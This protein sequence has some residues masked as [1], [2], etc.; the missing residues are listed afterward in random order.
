MTTTES[1]AF[2]LLERA[3]CDEFRQALPLFRQVENVVWTTWVWRR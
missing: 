3:A 1:A 2:E